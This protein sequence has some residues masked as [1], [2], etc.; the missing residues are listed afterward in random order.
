MNCHVLPEPPVKTKMGFPI[1][2]K[3][4]KANLK[5]D[6]NLNNRVKR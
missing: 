6:D 4:K 2:K 5:P 1:K 3:K